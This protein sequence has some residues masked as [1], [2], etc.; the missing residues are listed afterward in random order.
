[1]TG[2]IRTPPGQVPMEHKAVTTIWLNYPN[3][4][5]SSHINIENITR[6]VNS[7]GKAVSEETNGRGNKEQS[8]TCEEFHQY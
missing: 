6:D 4:L 2:T 5:N 3:N 1:M 7:E 8:L